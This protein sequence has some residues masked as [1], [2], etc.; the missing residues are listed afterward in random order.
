VADFRDHHVKEALDRTVGPYRPEKTARARLKR[1][2]AIATL[3]LVAVLA[4]VGIIQVSTPRPATPAPA[5]KPGKID[6]LLV[7]ARP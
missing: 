4:F 7:P 6:V 1:I 3:T 2:A 5:P